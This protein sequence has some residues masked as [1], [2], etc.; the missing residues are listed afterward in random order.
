MGTGLGKC[1]RE[2]RGMRR[3]DRTQRDDVQPG[4]SVLG[5]VELVYV[6]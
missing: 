2:G 6:I 5:T 4:A 1:G 3:V